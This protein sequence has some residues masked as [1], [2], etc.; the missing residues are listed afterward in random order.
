[1]HVENI[2][3]GWVLGVTDGW[4]LQRGRDGRTAQPGRDGGAARPS[5][6][7]RRGARHRRLG[8]VPRQQ[9]VPAGA[10]Q[11]A[12]LVC[13]DRGHRQRRQVRAGSGADRRASMGASGE[14]W[15]RA[16]GI[17]RGVR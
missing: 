9:A 8:L 10:L 3:G 7:C 17:N 15:A 4:T 6:A 13:A 16:G 14:G 1:M 12:A 5:G 2:G 11:R